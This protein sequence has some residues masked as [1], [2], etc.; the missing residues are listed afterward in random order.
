MQQTLVFVVL[1]VTLVLF[2]WG[3]FRYE[4][5]ALAAL[6]VLVLT[7]VV[8]PGDAFLGFGHPAVITV[9]AVLVITRGLANAGVADWLAAPL[10]RV[11]NN[12]LLQVT[13]LSAVVTVLSAFINN[14]GALALLMPVAIRIA[15]RHQLPISL[16][17]MPMAFASLLGGLIT[18]IGTPPNL[19]VAAFRARESGVPFG[20][21]DFAAVGLPIAAI[22]VLFMSLL[23]WR[24]LPRRNGGTEGELTFTLPGYMTEIRVP[25]NSKHAGL[26]LGDIEEK[27]G[28]EISVFGLVRGDRRI[29][30]RFRNE[31]IRGGDVLIVHGKA[32]SLK[33][34]VTNLGFT[35]AGRGE[36]TEQMLKST[37]LYIAE[38]V[39]LNDAWASG[40]TARSMNLRRRYG[41]NLLAVSRQGRP[42][43]D[44]LSNVRWKSGDVLLIEGD[45]LQLQEDL[46]ELG[47]LPLAARDHQLGRPRQLLMG[48][49]LLAGTV[50]IAAVGWVPIQIGFIGCVLAMAV[51]GMFSA[52]EAYRALDWPVLILLAAMVPIGAAMESSGGAAWIAQKMGALSAG[53]APV[54]GLTLVLVTTMC[55]SDI[56][57]NAAAAILMCPIA[58]GVAAGLGVATDPFLMAVAIGASCAFLTPVGHQ[59]NTLVMGPGGYRFSDYWRVGLPLEILIGIVAIWMIPKAWPF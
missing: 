36:S 42:L 32:E 25:E 16:L 43:T 19:I 45:R 20:M 5:V 34:A 41:M 1:A 53:S 51:A 9:A 2:M 44:S 52:R 47:C 12:V 22:G 26:S 46:T 35:L 39:V 11:G 49:L 17:L 59:S 6:L 30:G 57:N 3:R 29:A 38:V 7:D 27:L 37:D 23:G 50:A 33:T 15:R 14:V 54:V 24:L 31:P 13:A 10:T 56:I 40:K 18:V 4:A 28:D 48:V 58:T 55:L 21:F 8:P